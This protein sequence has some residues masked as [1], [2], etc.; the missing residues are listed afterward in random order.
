MELLHLTNFPAVPMSFTEIQVGTRMHSW[1]TNNKRSACDLKAPR[2]V[3]T[4]EVMTTLRG[5]V[6]FCL[7]SIA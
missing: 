1:L 3:S 2:W 6:Y 4:R 7:V 5:N